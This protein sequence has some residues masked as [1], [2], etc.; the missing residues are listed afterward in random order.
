VS[1]LITHNPADQPPDDDPTGVRDLLSSLP[2]PAPMPLYLV[3]RINASLAAEQAQ[4]TANTSTTSVTPLLAPTRRRPGRLVF[5]VAGA[6][7]AVVLFAVVGN[8]I[9]QTSRSTTISGSASAPVT[10][11]AREGGGQALQGAA[12]KATRQG[13]M[14]PAGTPPLVQIRLSGTRYTQAGF[15]TQVRNLARATVDQ[16]RPPA[17]ASAD[18]GPVGTTPGLLDCLNAIGAGGVQ[19][20]RADL[21]FYEGRPAVIIVATTNGTPM[22]YAVGRHCSRADAAVLRPATPL[23]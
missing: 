22:A 7:A 17:A 15:V 13:A 14:S 8:D 1:T 9:F 6:A 16:I 21:A 18:I 20:V 19:M 10:S 3:E 11:G 2:Q 4:R 23:P 12:D 5:A